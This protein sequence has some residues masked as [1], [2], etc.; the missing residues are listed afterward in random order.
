MRTTLRVSWVLTLI[1][2]AASGSTRPATAQVHLEG[3]IGPGSIYAIDVPDDWNHDLVLYAH[4]IVQA[5]QPVAPPTTQDGY[6]FIRD[7]LLGAGY[8]LAASSYSSNGYVLDDAVRRTHQLGGLFTSKFGRP[9]RMF[10]MGHSLGALTIVKMA[11][12]Y[13]TQYVGALPMC[14]PLGGALASIQYA[15]DARVT[16]D[17]YFP[18]LLPGSPFSVPADTLFLSPFDPGGPSPLFMAVY[19]ALAADPSAAFQWATA[20]AL[21]FANETELGNS[22]L[23]VIGFILR[24][25]NDF[26]ERVNGKMPYDNTDILYEVNVT[27]DPVTNAHL[28]AL[29]NAGVARYEADRAATNF[30]ERNYAPTGRISVPVLTLHTTRDPGVPFAHEAAFADSVEAAGRSQWLRQILVDRWGHCAFTPDEVQTAFEQ[31]VAWVD[32]GQP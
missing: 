28:S 15:G 10:L 23:Y 4:A 29:L 19:G 24:Y 17:Y 32:S 11:E 20:A 16:F 3:P 13:P 5:S 25:T 6:A 9:R 8:A 27:P 12:R 26:I 30:Y 7:R 1:A 14:G 2:I 22:A 31:L 18:G 21:P